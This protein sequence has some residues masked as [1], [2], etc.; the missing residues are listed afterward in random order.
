MSDYTEH[1]KKTLHAL[2]LDIEQARSRLEASDPEGKAT[3]LAELGQLNIRHDH[4]AE[5]IAVAR[6]HGSDDW[7]AFRTS[8]QEDVDAL[9]DTLER[10]LTRM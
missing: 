4:L 8:L 9:E 10:W 2:D 1:L 6:E 7:S 3:L 5:R